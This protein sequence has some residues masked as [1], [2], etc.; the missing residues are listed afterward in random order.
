M[1]H[2]DNDKFGEIALSLGFCTA[3]QIRSCLDIQ[4]DTTENLSLGQS[5]L[6]EGFISGEQYSRVLTLLRSSLG[7]A[8]QAP[9]DPFQPETSGGL[10]N[11]EVPTA[12]E[13]E[14]DL[15]GKL[16]VRE[17]WIAAA[18]LK[19]C[20][21]R[22]K[23]GTP[24]QPLAKILVT[25][26]YLTPAR[27]K[28]LLARVSRRLMFC[29]GCEKSFTVLSIANSRNVNCPHCRKPLE[30]GKLPDRRPAE[31]P[32]ATQTFRVISQALPPSSRPRLQ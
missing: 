24:R 9:D 7:K 2:I 19:A 18:D 29:R 5:L 32:L 6:R 1:D 30:E 20:L 22:E 10:T 17:G 14:D 12:E 11:P 25:K 26:G 4:R 3:D 21:Q 8:R 16:A 23:P 13:R 15:L 28:D 27:A 31:D